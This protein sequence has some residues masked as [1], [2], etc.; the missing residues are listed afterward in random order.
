L[1]D[2]YTYIMTN[3]SGTLYVGVT[4]N[5]EARVLQHKEGVNDGFTKRYS[6]DRLV[7]YEHTNDVTAA[8]AREKQIKG[9]LRS[10]KVALINAENPEWR[11]LSEDWYPLERP[12]VLVEGEILRSAQNDKVRPQGDRSGRHLPD[13]SHL[14]PEESGVRKTSH[15]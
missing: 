6:I 4:N 13:D 1:H 8:I 3:R 5:L 9:W 2:Y 12:R 7:Y 10:K 11:D 14:F 15:V